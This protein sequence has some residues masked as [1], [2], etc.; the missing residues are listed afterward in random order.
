VHVIDGDA[1]LGQQFL[2]VPVGQSI[3]QVPADRDRDH[4]PREPGTG[5]RRTLWTFPTTSSNQSPAGCDRPTQHCP[6]GYSAVAGGLLGR[7]WGVR[8]LLMPGAA[9]GMPMD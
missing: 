6:T 8:Y 1:A 4:L 2:D 7:I 5:S 9:V 3:A